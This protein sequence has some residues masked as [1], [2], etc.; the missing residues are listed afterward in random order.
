[1]P[2]TSIASLTSF[3]NSNVNTNGTDSI[4]GA[5]LNT[6]LNG[7]I[8]YLGTYGAFNVGTYST[9]VTIATSGASFQSITIPLSV[10]P[11][12]AFAQVTNNPSIDGFVTLNA[13]ATTGG[14]IFYYESLFSGTRTLNINYFYI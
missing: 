12:I 4:T 1:M 3:V 8:Q 7:I 5:N 14:I 13:V 9:P 2:F 6:S 11:V 10:T